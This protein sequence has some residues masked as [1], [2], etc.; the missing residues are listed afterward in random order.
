MPRLC[1]FQRLLLLLIFWLR[2]NSKTSHQEKNETAIASLAITNCCCYRLMLSNKQWRLILKLAL[3]LSSSINCPIG[4]LA[5]ESSPSIQLLQNKKSTTKWTSR[6]PRLEKEKKACHSPA[7]LPNMDGSN[8]GSLFPA[9][10]VFF[11]LRER[12]LLADTKNCLC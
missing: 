6:D 4:K 3:Q 11:D 2:P 9:M 5:C 12:T 7:L 10:T 8:S 1:L